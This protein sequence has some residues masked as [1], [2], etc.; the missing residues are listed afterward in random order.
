M[1]VVVIGIVA[2]IGVLYYISIR[3]SFVS[4]GGQVE[5]S[6]ANIDVILK[7]RF[8]EVGQLVQVVEQYTKNE[9]SNLLKL[10]QARQGYNAAQSPEQKVEMAKE[11]GSA[12]RGVIA[13]AENYPDLKSNQ[14]F[15]QLQ[16]RI[17]TLED[18]LSDRREQYN[19]FATSF[20]IR[21]QQFPDSIIAGQ[22]QLTRKALYQV[23]ESEKVKPNLKMNL[24]S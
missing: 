15:M 14:N 8:D 10:V 1:V 20:N 18:S 22:M 3:N 19:D 21:L 4:L 7:Q 23:D 5:Q 24:G 13:L 16:S 11:M 6:W 2:V 12:I 9:N 17:S